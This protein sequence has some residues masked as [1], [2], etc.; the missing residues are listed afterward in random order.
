MTSPLQRPPHPPLSPPEIHP[1]Y[2]RIHPQTPSPLRR[3]L[4]RLHQLTADRNKR[5]KSRFLVA[6]CRSL[7]RNDKT[8]IHRTATNR[9]LSTD[10]VPTQVGITQISQMGEGKRPNIS[11]ATAR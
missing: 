7:A 10:A 1:P 5:R 9:Y 8:G 3:E 4:N 11:G 6:A 2:S